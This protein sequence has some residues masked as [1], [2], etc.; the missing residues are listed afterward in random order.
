MLNVILVIAIW[1]GSE[2]GTMQSEMRFRKQEVCQY[3]AD[4]AIKNMR[5]KRPEWDFHYRCIER[6]EV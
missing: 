1:D 6:H 5:L 3:A 2:W 4:L